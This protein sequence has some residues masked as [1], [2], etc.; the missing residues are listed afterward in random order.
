MKETN[1]KI[2]FLR[3]TL[4]QIELICRDIVVNELVKNEPD[5][6]L[7]GEVSNIAINAIDGTDELKK[8]LKK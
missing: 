5:F 3:E 2:E 6:D 1:V 4:K 7:L 8:W